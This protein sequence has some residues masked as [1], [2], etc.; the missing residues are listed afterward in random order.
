MQSD[1][2]RS[3]RDDGLRIGR[4]EGAERSWL[5]LLREFVPNA[6]RTTKTATF[7]ASQKKRRK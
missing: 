6:P 4:L 7:G 5:T 3:L 1:G 2:V